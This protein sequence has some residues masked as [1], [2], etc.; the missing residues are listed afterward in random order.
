M[1]LSIIIPVHNGE[2]YL[3][4][5]FQCLAA[6][7]DR[8]YEAIFV[9]DGSSDQT[10]ARFYDMKAKY[11]QVS[12]VLYS[13]EQNQ[14]VSAARNFGIERATGELISFCDVDDLIPS[15]YV[16]FIRESFHRAEL[17]VVLWRFVRCRPTV[18][19]PAQ[20][21]GPLRFSLLDKR[22]TMKNY[23]FKKLVCGCWCWC[24]RVEFVKTNHIYYDTNAHYG[25]DLNFLWKMLVSANT[26]GF[27]DNVLYYYLI[28]NGSA[29]SRFDE[30]RLEGY[31]LAIDFTDDVRKK[32][33]DFAPLYEKYEGPRILWS[34]AWQG[35]VQLGRDEFEKYF[36]GYPLKQA[37]DVLVAYPQKSVRMT[38]KLYT[39]SPWLFWRVMR[40]VGKLRFSY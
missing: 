35:A 3:K 25:E 40:L 21:V 39:Y 29:M 26:I 34:L 28:Q 12:A 16:E 38:A 5:M 9:N 6:Q 2:R 27:I 30:R 13:F 19:A 10:D 18:S 33:P 8:D 14:G 24:G 31:R 4:Q 23:L 20:E 36:K 22:E 7:T 11:R 1:K 17:D 15:C 32:C 37:M